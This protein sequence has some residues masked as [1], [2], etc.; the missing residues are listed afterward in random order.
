[1]G[2]RYEKEQIRKERMKLETAQSPKSEAERLESPKRSVARLEEATDYDTRNNDRKFRY[3]YAYNKNKERSS[4]TIYISEKEDGKWSEEKL[5][6]IGTY[7]YEYDTQDRVKTKTVKYTNPEGYFRSYRIMVDYRQDVTHYSRYE[8]TWDDNLELVESWSYHPNGILAS[9]Y[10]EDWDTDYHNS[11]EYFYSETGMQTAFK[12]SEGSLLFEI[13]GTLND[14]T[15]YTEDNGMERY[16]LEHYKYDPNTGKLLEYSYVE[17][18]DYYSED[19]LKEVYTYDDLGR[20]TRVQ[21]YCLSDD[22]VDTG[23]GIEE[24]PGKEETDTAPIVYATRAGSRPS[25]E[26]FEW[27]LEYEETYTYFNDEV[28]SVGNSWHDVFGFDGPLTNYRLEEGGYSSELQFQRDANGKL[29]GVS[30]QNAE[31]PNVKMDMQ[32]SVDDMG[33]I[34]QTISDYE[35][36]WD[37]YDDAASS[38]IG[39]IIYSSKDVNTYTW[40][41]GKITS[42]DNEYSYSD[43]YPNGYNYSFEDKKHYALTYGENCV[44]KVCTDNDGK[45]S[46][47]Y[48]EQKGSKWYQIMDEP[49]IYGVPCVSLIEVQQEDVSFVRPNVMKDLDGFEPEETIIASVKDRVV[50]YRSDDYTDAD[51]WGVNPEETYSYYANVNEDTYFSISHQGENTVCSDIE[52]LPVYILNNGRLLREYE[53]YE[54][55]SNVGSVGGFATAYG[56]RSAT[57]ATSDYAY[58]ETSYLYDDSGLLI[59]KTIVEVDID[60]KKTEEIKLEYKYDDISGITTPEVFGKPGITLNERV[61]GLADGRKFS[62]Y[63]TSGIML[64]E[65]VTSH[66]FTAA[67]IY[68]IKV[69]HT[70]I[71]VCVK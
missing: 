14:C 68:V 21:R 38:I 50:A 61:L 54:M 9:H 39:K 64:T 33:Q 16:S 49:I 13:S 22:E 31:I 32:I 19:A 5:Y 24:Q 25:L 29:T 71:K 34:V 63:T 30:C 55:I 57:R 40:K 27:I 7:T 47:C 70:N 48:T 4:E 37:A 44:T 23:G 45:Q 62:V 59:G 43:S 52:G 28:Y 11:G 6:D 67:G 60:G 18:S 46:T 53:Y 17:D 56:T 26:D 8:W 20:L 12:T 10:K 36:S 66:T 15:V 41:N 65:G 51:G 58:T 3:I 42:Y 35:E 69:G 1:M 2:L